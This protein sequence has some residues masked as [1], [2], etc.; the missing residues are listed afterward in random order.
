MGGGHV[1][2]DPNKTRVH[3]DETF[4]DV[5][6]ICEQGS[7]VVARDRC[8]ACEDAALPEVKRDSGQEVL[9]GS[10]RRPIQNRVEVADRYSNMMTKLKRDKKF[11]RML[12]ANEKEIKD[13]VYKA[14]EYGETDPKDIVRLIDS[15]L[16]YK[17]QNQGATPDKELL[18]RIPGELGKIAEL[19]FSE[20]GEAA[21][22]LSLVYE[23]L[24]HSVIDKELP[25]L[26]L[27]ARN[28]GVP[29]RE[30]FRIFREAVNTE[31]NTPWGHVY[32]MRHLTKSICRMRPLL[33]SGRIMKSSFA[34]YAVEIV[35]RAGDDV[36]IALQELPER[37]IALTE[38]R[39]AGD[40]FAYLECDE[41]VAPLLRWTHNPGDHVGVWALLKREELQGIIAMCVQ[42]GVMDPDRMAKIIMSMSETAQNTSFGNIGD[43]IDNLDATFR[44][45]RKMGIS[46]PGHMAR[47]A[48]I[49]LRDTFGHVEH[50]IQPVMEAAKDAGLSETDA[51]EILESLGS[52]DNH[53]MRRLEVIRVLPNALDNPKVAAFVRANGAK[54]LVDRASLIIDATGGKAKYAIAMLG[55]VA[56]MKDVSDD[57]LKRVLEVTSKQ[58]YEEKVDSH[59]RTRMASLWLAPYFV[60]MNMTGEEDISAILEATGFD[61]TARR[62][63]VERLGR[64]M[65]VVSGLLNRNGISD[66]GD[67]S[68]L[69]AAAVKAG[70]DNAEYSVG[71]LPSFVAQMKSQGKTMDEMAEII[72][73][74]ACDPK[75]L[76]D[77]DRF[78]STLKSKGLSKNSIDGLVSKRMTVAGV[79]KKA[80]VAELLAGVD[81]ME[82]L[83]LDLRNGE[84]VGFLK[85]SVI[86]V[87]MYGHMKSGAKILMD[88]MP[89]KE[90]RTAFFRKHGAF[91]FAHFVSFL[92][93]SKGDP[94][95]GDK[96]ADEIMATCLKLEEKKGL[97]MWRY[98]S[99]KVADYLLDPNRY[100]SGYDIRVVEAANENLIYDEL[101]ALPDYSQPRMEMNFHGSRD[102]MA[103][104]RRGMFDKSVE[105]M[106]GISRIGETD[107][108]R[109]LDYTRMVQVAEAI[110]AMGRMRIGLPPEARN[111]DMGD[112]EWSEFEKKF[113]PP[114]DGVSPVKKKPVIVAITELDRNGAFAGIYRDIELLIDHERDTSADPAELNLHACSTGAGEDNI[115]QK[116]SGW[117]GG[118]RVTAPPKPV[119][120]GLIKDGDRVRPVYRSD[121]VVVDPK[122]YGGDE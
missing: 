67:R 75:S 50:H 102:G 61:H 47:L 60:E 76:A 38:E 27:A 58:V 20:T 46:D 114:P 80:A 15:A 62:S 112:T 115:S 70:G 35:K 103:A 93:N 48:P 30:A 118:V 59:W 111:I 87:P 64:K 82:T 26:A 119:S 10:G 5:P 18:A 45:L 117:L 40:A 31:K 32:N 91:K 84:V 100:N 13:I 63:D 28:A 78:I 105:E 99:Y 41:R 74:T 55:D 104:G 44:G 95:I 36:D 96:S 6:E 110:D 77:Y 54:A 39:S 83:G 89:S 42:N 121:S 88:K 25:C 65:T 71:R 97:R 24:H 8:C 29:V 9:F 7:E 109:K 68:R 49:G 22:V 53:G 86:D 73:I 51:I 33:E 120:S 57:V 4:S 19:G 66:S 92:S 69:M 43:F 79:G 23:K 14:V 52:I 34:D 122:V 94:R 116:I 3:Q 90:A 56:E 108:F 21:E 2:L 81:M 16:K 113:Q 101:R 37:L 85:V 98:Y 11:T 17:R 72:E 107:F 12:R 106:F 1:G